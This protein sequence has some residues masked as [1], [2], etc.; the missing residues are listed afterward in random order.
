MGEISINLGPKELIKN[1]FRGGGG[2]GGG[3][4]YYHVNCTDCSC[5]LVWFPDPSVFHFRGGRGGRAGGRR[6]GL[7]NNLALAWIHGCIPAV[8]VENTNLE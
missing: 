2:G 1:W 4:H 7:V 3:V 5:S 6:K 8:S